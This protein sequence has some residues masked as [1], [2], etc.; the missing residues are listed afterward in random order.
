[1]RPWLRAGRRRVRSWREGITRTRR[2]APRTA[3]PMAS[4][5]ALSASPPSWLWRKP[6]VEFDPCIDVAA[7]HAAPGAADQRRYAER[8]G[9]GAAFGGDHDRERTERG[10]SDES[11]IGAMVPV[12]ARSSATSVV[13]SRPAMVAGRSLPSANRIKTSPS[14]ASA[15]SAVDDEAG[16]PDEARSARAVRVDGDDGRRGSGDD[17]RRGLKRRG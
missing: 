15:S 4:P 11:F 14:S 8:G 7:A 12:S 6:H 3:M 1:M 17:A 10:T 2:R 5:A 16:L 13:W 9:R